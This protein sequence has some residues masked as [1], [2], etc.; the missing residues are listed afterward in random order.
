MV[1]MRPVQCLCVLGAVAA[2]LGTAG[3]SLRGADDALR[4]LDDSGRAAGKQEDDGGGDG[5]L[6]QILRDQAAQEAAETGAE[7]AITDDAPSGG[8]PPTG[9]PKPG[10]VQATPD[11]EQ[12][13][14]MEIPSKPP[15]RSPERLDRADDGTRTR[16]L[17]LGKLSLYQVSYFR[18]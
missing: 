13:K 15:T 9:I 12:P 2:S 10:P 16:Y 1:S 6:R 18:F 17:Q 14:P 3:C 5:E 11:F 8:P 4:A 7:D